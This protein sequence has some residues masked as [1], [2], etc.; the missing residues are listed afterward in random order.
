MGE[1][2]FPMTRHHRGFQKSRNSALTVAVFFLTAGLS[3][4]LAADQPTPVGD[5]GRLTEAGLTVGDGYVAPG[6]VIDGPPVTVESAPAPA[7][8]VAETAETPPALPVIERVGTVDPALVIEKSETPAM[9]GTTVARFAAAQPEAAKPA[10]PPAMSRQLADLLAQ[11]SESDANDPLEPLNRVI[12]EINYF[13]ERLLLRPA[14]DLYVLMLPQEARDGIRNFLRNI[15]TPIVLANDLLQGEGE[16]A[17]QTTQRFFINSTIG[18]GGV[19]DAADRFGIKHHNEDLGQTFA[20]WGVDEIVYLV[21]PIFGPS[22]PRD[23]VGDFLDRYF[24]PVWYWTENTDRE[25]IQIARSVVGGV[26]SYSRVMAE[27]DKLRETSVDFYAA[28]RSIYRQKRDADIRN[29]ES[30]DVPLPEIQY[31]FNA[32]LSVN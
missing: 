8:Q 1:N 26:D 15:R 4:P 31:D 25:E 29:G 24:D 21:L 11:A 3:A 13:L 14:A 12:F 6:F 7:V 17:W 28:M 18:V 10:A 5:G 30:K 22:N 9:A 16:R 23:A 20:V 27:L 2:D 19:I 32:D